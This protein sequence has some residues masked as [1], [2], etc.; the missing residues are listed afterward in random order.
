MNILLW[1]VLTNIGIL[2]VADPAL[3]E[4]LLRDDRLTI[5]VKA[6]PLE[7][8]LHDLSRQG[9]FQVT[10][11]EKQTTRGL[12]VT[13]H[14]DQLPIEEGLNR[15]LADWNY[16]LTKSPKSGQIQEVF[17]VSRRDNSKDSSA[18]SQSASP[19]GHA[20]PS[21]QNPNVPGAV[22][23]ISPENPDFANEAEDEESVDFTP[24]ESETEEE[25]F[26][27]DML[28]DDLLP[29]SRAAIM[30]EYRRTNE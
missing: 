19:V 28:P 22:T 18:I 26:T 15:L 1:I 14:F 23:P 20:E 11:L 3:A 17:L 7:T 2:G 21:S 8:I 12:L 5:N 29:E 24:E 16:S 25:P 13:E 30:E 4:L 6:V 27:E 9:A 10:V